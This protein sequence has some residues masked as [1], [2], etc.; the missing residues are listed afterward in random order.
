[1]SN[2]KDTVIKDW[3]ICEMIHGD[4]KWLAVTP[5]IVDK[6]R[7]LLQAQVE[8]TWKARNPEIK[9][10][11]KAGQEAEKAHWAREIERQVHD[12]YEGGI[13]KVMEFVDKHI[14]FGNIPASY[15][16]W[17]A[18]KES[19]RIEEWDEGSEETRESLAKGHG[20]TFPNAEETINWLTDGG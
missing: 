20:I 14:A 13:Q 9:E 11:H 16:E 18:F 15:K 19:K 8:I 6:E 2:W 12:A 17:Q 5:W 1:M 10:A 4:R 3:K 7:K